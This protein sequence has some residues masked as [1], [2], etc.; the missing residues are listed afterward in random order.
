[1]ALSGTNGITIGGAYPSFSIGFGLELANTRFGY[2]DTTGFMDLTTVGTNY[3]FNGLFTAGTTTYT[4]YASSSAFDF[5]S[6][7]ARIKCNFTGNVFVHMVFSHGQGLSDYVYWVNRSSQGSGTTA[8]LNF[9]SNNDVTDT[10]TQ[11]VVI[12]GATN[13]VSGE[14]MRVYVERL[15]GSLGNN[16][17]RLS[18]TFSFTLVRIN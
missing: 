2:G 10:H 17:T 16:T 5:T 6:G 4:N 7:V 12:S 11:T 8:A 3:E 14:Y 15:S 1:V 13:V 9:R 18:Q